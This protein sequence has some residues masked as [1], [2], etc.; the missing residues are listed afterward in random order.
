MNAMGYDL[1][2]VWAEKSPG[3]GP[4][5]WIEIK[6]KKR[7]HVSAR[8]LVPGHSGSE[9]LFKQNNSVKTMSI[10]FNGKTINRSCSGEFFPARVS[11]DAE[12]DSIRVTILS[13]IR[14]SKYNALCIGEVML[15][16]K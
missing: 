14:G 12:V 16:R 15:L 11:I 6:L 4:G 13:V 10:T 3:D 2:T 7:Q 5:E 8:I 9:R 1:Q